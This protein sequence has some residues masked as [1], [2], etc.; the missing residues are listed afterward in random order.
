[1]PYLS[2]IRRMQEDYLLRLSLGYIHT[3]FLCAHKQ[4]HIESHWDFV[5]A[6]FSGVLCIDEVH[7]SGRTI[8]FATD[9]PWVTLRCRSRWPAKMISHTWTGF[10][11]P[12]KIEVSRPRRSSPTARRFTKTACNATGLRS[13]INCVSSTSSRQAV[14]KLILDGVRTIKNRLKR[15][16]NKGR[17][18][19]RVQAPGWDRRRVPAVLAAV[20][21]VAVRRLMAFERRQDRLVGRARVDSSPVPARDV[22]G[23]S[24]VCPATRGG[25]AQR[26]DPRR[27][28]C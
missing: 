18:K 3:C 2:V 13:S 15:Q 1:M 11:K 23:G 26:P 16:G 14:N 4:I 28:S 12:S 17:K 6:N 24:L 20:Q 21:R 9:L 27:A 10:Y 8:L 22:R 5:H 25:P 7:D 19:G